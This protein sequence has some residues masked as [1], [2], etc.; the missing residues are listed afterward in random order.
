MLAVFV[1]KVCRKLGKKGRKR[2]RYK[3]EP[4]A[5]RFSLLLDKAHRRSAQK[6]GQ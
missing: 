5:C 3:W 2:G 6:E 1:A 4:A